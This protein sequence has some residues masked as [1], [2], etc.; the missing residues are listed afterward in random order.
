MSLFDRF[1]KKNAAQTAKQNQNK[2]E[3]KEVN[4]VSN[5]RFET[6]QIHVGQESPDISTDARAVP[7]YATTSYVFKDSKTAA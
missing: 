6:L 7:I 1:K 5:Y 4:T 2:N 3:K